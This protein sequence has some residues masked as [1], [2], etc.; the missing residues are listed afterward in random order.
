MQ[1][2]DFQ[3]QIEIKIYEFCSNLSIAKTPP[4]KVHSFSILNSQNS[5]Q[6][7]LIVPIPTFVKISLNKHVL[8]SEL[9][10]SWYTIERTFQAPN[11]SYS[12]SALCASY[13]H[14]YNDHKR[15][16]CERFV[17]V[18]MKEGVWVEFEFEIECEASF[19]TVAHLPDACLAE[20][21]STTNCAALAHRAEWK[22]VIRKVEQF[23]WTAWDRKQTNELNRWFFSLW[24]T[25]GRFRSKSFVAPVKQVFELHMRNPL[26]YNTN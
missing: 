25:V 22:T 15:I 23:R 17:L 3:R 10:F 7:N 2:F 5:V 6:V 24:L 21:F 19:H 11:G 16:V 12:L 13:N 4:E 20:H 8:L 26:L 14:I 1:M 9:S 18:W